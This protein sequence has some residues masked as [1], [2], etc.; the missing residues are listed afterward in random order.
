MAPR[1]SSRCA[2]TANVI[3]SFALISAKRNTKK[4][5]ATFNPPTLA[6]DTFGRLRWAIKPFNFSSMETP[7]TGVIKKVSVSNMASPRGGD[8]PNQFI[9]ETP[10]G[11]Y[12][13]SY[14]SIVAFIPYGDGKTVLDAKTWDYSTTT[15][16]Y[17]N[18]FLREDK[19]TTEKKIASGEYLL[20]DLNA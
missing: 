20:A 8:V 15:G 1:W 9:I 5:L 2:R 16:K 14:R 18:Q 6:P 3:K 10:E 7:T 12:F 19:R 17:R 11:R 4:K 13:Q